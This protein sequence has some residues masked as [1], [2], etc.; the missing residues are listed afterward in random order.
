MKQILTDIKG[1]I[2]KNTI[3]I[4]NFKTP[5]TSVDR[6]S[7]QKISKGTL[8]LNYTL[9]KVK[10]KSFIR[11][12]FFATP[13]TLAYQVPPSKGFS[14]QEYWSGLPFPSP[15]DLPE[16]NRNMWNIAS[17]STRIHILFQCT[18]SVLQDR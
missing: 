4:A 17:K 18:K 7:S 3:I 8:D 2:D 1:E 6:S 13:W 5:L 15:G 12:Q 11:V 10:V 14:R 16:I 9:K